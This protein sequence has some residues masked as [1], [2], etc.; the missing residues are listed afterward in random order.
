MTTVAHPA[1]SYP[2]PRRNPAWARLLQWGTFLL[3]GVAI[4]G[5]FVPLVY[6][7]LR[8]RPLYEAGGRWTLGAYREILADPAFW[9]AVKN[10]MVFAS[11]STLG[12]VV[13][14]AALAI[15]CT[16][17]D[18][19]GSRSFGTI[20]LLPIMLP[21]LGMVLGWL[22]TW[23]PGGFGNTLLA[24]VGIPTI[25]IDTLPGMS[26]VQATHLMPI[27][28]LTC[29][30]ALRRTDSSLEDAAR[31]AGATPLRVMRT[32]T[33][34]LLRPALL[35][36]ALLVFTLCIAALGI[37]LLLGASN[38]IEFV[39][40]FLYHTWVNATE[41]DS[42]IVSAGAMLLVLA[43][44]LLL[45]LRN[46]LLGSE[47][48]FVSVTGRGGK[49]ETLR[50]GV[51]RLPLAIL[52][53]LFLF[54]TTFVPILGL[55]I[56]SFVT[57]L[58]PLLA[59]WELFTWDNWKALDDP[60]FIRSIK[61]SILISLVGALLTVSLVALATLVAHRSRF[62]LRKPMPFVMLYPRAIPGLVLGIGFFWTYLLVDWPGNW[63]R[64]TI[65]GIMVAFCVRA[66]PFAY[67]VL[68][69]TMTRIG[70]ELDRASRASGAGWMRTSW[71]IVL[72][73]MRPAIFAAFILL[74][75]ELLAEYDA[76]LFL[77]KPGTE[78]IGATMVSQ[79]VQGTLGPVAALAMVQ[80]GLTLLVLVVGSRV[81]KIGVPGGSH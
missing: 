65:W 43:A 29:Q 61:N 26:F 13:L 68:Y 70:E 47:L 41:P 27:A 31:S 64:A 28:F 5:P 60:V 75:V 18:M 66:F 48:R 40:S 56:M 52:V 59:P 17:T 73:L 69:P 72:P 11:L 9:T 1:E 49:N 23:G 62:P 32:I 8:D 46:V 7:S 16:R 30:A 45:V 6:A 19:P 22:V 78:V 12:A 38:S 50:L 10:T 57:F 34:P 44:T 33:I 2:R 81:F 21:S 63:L 58:T 25:E 14:G 42:P 36:S 35:N 37:P 74:F 4:L 51:W 55:G 39:S 76:A 24:N 54:L 20:G 79:F 71:S 3:V 80:I 15:L 67:V 77:V 53:G